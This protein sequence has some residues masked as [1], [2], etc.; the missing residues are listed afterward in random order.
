M[1]GPMEDVAEPAPASDSVVNI[2]SALTGEAITT[3]HLPRIAS[4]QH[5]KRHIQNEVGINMYRPKILIYPGSEIALDDAVL[6]AFP[7]PLTVT[8]VKMLHIEDDD[9][10]NRL[11]LAADDGNIAPV[12]SLLSM[13]ASPDG[14]DATDDTPMVRASQRGHLDVVRLLCDAWADK[15]KAVNGGCGWR[16]MHVACV[17]GHLEV[18]RFLCDAGADKDNVDLSG[19]TPM[20]NACDYGHLEITRLLCDAGA[21][22]DKA[23]QDGHTPMHSA[24]E[25]GRLEL[26]R[27][28]CVA[29][30][31][32]DQADHDGRTPMY[33][34]CCFEHLEVARLLIDAGADKDKAMLDG[35]TPMHDACY[36]GYLEVTRLLCDA[37]AD[38]DKADESGWGANACRMCQRTFGNHAVLMWRRGL[39]GKCGPRW[40]DANSSRMYRRALGSHTALV[41]CRG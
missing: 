9:V 5:V 39:Q 29:G 34:A 38:K 22:K 10:N 3:V 2:V 13:P 33:L 4:I 15:D 23:D 30:A 14:S 7:D 41:R 35:R 16:P 18:T 32:K 31:D 21:A 26:T 27:L 19:V 12:T 6:S 8:L 25:D 37:G 1:A 17:A 28:L 20:L 36:K 11:L 40:L 24:C